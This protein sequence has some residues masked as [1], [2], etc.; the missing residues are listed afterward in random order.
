LRERQKGLLAS[1]VGILNPQFW[2]AKKSPKSGETNSK[3]WQN[4][5]LCL[6]FPPHPYNSRQIS[7]KKKKLSGGRGG[8]GVATVLIWL[9][10]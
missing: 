4:F 5:S 2:G 3:I 8:E 7:L 6:S 10:F 1:L 9:L